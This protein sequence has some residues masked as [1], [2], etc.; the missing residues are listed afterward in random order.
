M[1]W[2][3]AVIL[4]LRALWDEG[5]STAEIGRRLGVTKN[6][7][8][9]KAHRL[10][11]PAR[12]SP[13]RRGAAP[14]ATARRATGPTLPSMELPEAAPQFAERQ[15]GRVV[16]VAVV[17]PVADAGVR[18]QEAPVVQVVPVRIVAV[19]EPAEAVEDEEVAEVPVHPVAVRSVPSLRPVAS[20]RRLRV[21]A[22]CWPI[23]EPGTRSFRFCDADSMAGKPYCDSHAQLAYVKVRDRREDAA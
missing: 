2:T 8:V 12:P 13:I 16:P 10:V 7:V 17:Q 19:R 15:A 9:G 1:D 4:S 21:V 20:P 5:L 6:A 11:L 22:C 23:G 18:P 14:V 3:D